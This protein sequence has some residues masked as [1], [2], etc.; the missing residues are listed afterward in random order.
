MVGLKSGDPKDFSSSAVMLTQ[1][2]N[3]QSKK[4]LASI[5]FIVSANICGKTW[6][7]LFTVDASACTIFKDIW[8]GLPIKYDLI[9]SMVTPC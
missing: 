4:N 6:S 5:V 8:K 3:D 2:K 7:G 1:T 9:K